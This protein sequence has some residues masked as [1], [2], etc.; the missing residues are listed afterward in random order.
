MS[1][2]INTGGEFYSATIGEK[3]T[4]VYKNQ[5][6]YLEFRVNLILNL[7]ELISTILNVK[8]CNIFAT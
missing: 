7:S 6:A 5:F 8:K 1:E 3:S 4:G 2:N